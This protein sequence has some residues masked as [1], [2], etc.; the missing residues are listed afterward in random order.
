MREG[1]SLP[2][3]NARS[4]SSPSPVFSLVFSDYS[5]GGGNAFFRDGIFSA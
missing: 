1:R 2:M 4:R 3:E 5:I